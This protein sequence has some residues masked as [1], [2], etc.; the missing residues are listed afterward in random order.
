VELV[1]TLEELFRRSDYV[2]VHAPGDPENYNLVNAER[3]ALMK[4]TA[5]LINTARGVLV[6]EDALYAALQAQTIAGAGLDVR[7]EEP[8]V[9]DR[10]ERLPNVVLTPH[11]AGSSEEA[12][13]ASAEM[14]VD[15]VLKAAEGEPPGGLL[16]PEVW[17]ARRGQTS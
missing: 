14:V 1:D 4:P 7:L 15:S 8:P 16:N 5:V 2:T 13:V 3:L 12:Q 11:I 10:F 6:D 9:E 17:P